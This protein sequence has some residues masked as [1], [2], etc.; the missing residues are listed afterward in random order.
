LNQPY[1]YVGGTTNPAATL[2][3]SGARLRVG[4]AIRFRRPF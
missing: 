3:L 1:P 4:A 2:D